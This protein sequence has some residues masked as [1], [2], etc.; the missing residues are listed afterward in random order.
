ME[1]SMPTLAKPQ[2]IAPESPWALDF[3]KELCANRVAILSA[4][5]FYAEH[6]LSADPATDPTEWEAEQLREIAGALS[7]AAAA[8]AVMPDRVLVA[9]LQRV[10]N[11]P[12]LLLTRELPATVEWAI[13]SVYQRAQEAPGTHWRDVAG[14]Q[15]ARFPGEVEQPTTVNIA[16]AARVAMET[17]RQ[18]RKRGRPYNLADQILADRLGAI[19]RRSGQLIRRHR[20]TIMQH[21]EAVYVERGGPFYNFLELVLPPLQQYLREHR[22]APATV[23]TIVRVASEDFPAT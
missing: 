22:L 10:A 11:N 1:R 19:F 2:L 7:V 17:L 4:V 13:A 21:G 6:G 20:E 3:Y 18:G 8:S 5:R 14:D 12:E 9:S 23:A 15:L 16:K